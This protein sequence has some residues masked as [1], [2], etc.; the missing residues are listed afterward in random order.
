MKDNENLGDI[1][2][3]SNGQSEWVQIPP[4]PPIKKPTP[5]SEIAAFAFYLECGPHC[6]SV[7]N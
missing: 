2:A 5:V 1:E 6:A 4:A 3:R 7:R